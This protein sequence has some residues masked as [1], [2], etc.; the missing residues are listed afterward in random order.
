MLP[1]GLQGST[2]CPFDM[3]DLTRGTEQGTSALWWPCPFYTTS[4]WS[5]N[6]SGTCKSCLQQGWSNLTP[7]T[8]QNLPA[9]PSYGYSK[10]SS[11]EGWQ[12]PP[13]S[14]VVCISLT[15]QCFQKEGGMYVPRDCAQRAKGEQCHLSTSSDAKQ[16]HPEERP[17]NSYSIFDLWEQ[18]SGTTNCHWK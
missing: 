12:V 11:R 6:S 9:L 15:I 8:N 5:K 14:N 16:I 3:Y 17:Q 10:V 18:F 4:L 7:P 2:P 1:L 13:I